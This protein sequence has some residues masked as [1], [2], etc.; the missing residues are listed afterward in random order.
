MEEEKLLVLTFLAL[1]IKSKV[2]GRTIIFVKESYFTKMVRFMKAIF[3]KVNDKDGVDTHIWMAKFI[4][5]NGKMMKNK[6]L[7]NI[8]LEINRFFQVIGVKIVKFMVSIKFK[9]SY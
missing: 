6:V 9:V 3:T 1:E 8:L 5:V 7:G 4:K 2:N